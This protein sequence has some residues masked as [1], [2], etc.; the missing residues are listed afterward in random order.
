MPTHAN[1]NPILAAVLAV[2][3]HQR[4]A[5]GVCRDGSAVARIDVVLAVL[6]AMAQTCADLTSARYVTIA[7]EREAA[8]ET[9]HYAEVHDLAARGALVGDAYGDALKAVRERFVQYH[10]AVAALSEAE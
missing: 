7:A 4:I 3:A 10:A 2:C 9:R 1:R 5:A 6:D 8:R